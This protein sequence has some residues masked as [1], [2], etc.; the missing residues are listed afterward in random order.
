[1]WKLLSKI[2]KE[3]NRW[4][5]SCWVIIV[6]KWL[7]KEY[8]SIFKIKKK[9]FYLLYYWYIVIQIDFSYNYVNEF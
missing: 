3:A 4:N 1:M 7:K 5:L 8:N 2:S 9:R 6:A